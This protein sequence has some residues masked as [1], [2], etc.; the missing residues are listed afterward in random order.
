MLERLLDEISRQETGGTF[1][2]SVVVT[3]NEPPEWLIKGGF[4][5]RP[6][7]PTGFLMP[8]HECRTGNVLFRRAIL[9]SSETPF[10]REFGTGGED[11]DFFRRMI[12]RGHR[13]VW[14]NEAVTFE[15]V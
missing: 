3:D 11:Q 7:H 5:Q 8:W 4:Y 14:C 12:E 15:L 6:T 13:F 10:R 9:N 2:Y 1:T